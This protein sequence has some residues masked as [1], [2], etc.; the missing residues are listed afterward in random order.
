MAFPKSIKDLCA[1]AMFY[2]YISIF[3]YLM[4]LFQNLGSLT[5]YNVGVYSCSFPNTILLFIF[6]LVYILFCT[7][8]LNLICKDGY[9]GISWLLVLFPFLLFFVLIGLVL[10][11]FNSNIYI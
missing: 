4:I 2:F 3:F 6:K 8:I 7:Y 5:S 10:L 1:P 9:T 11:N